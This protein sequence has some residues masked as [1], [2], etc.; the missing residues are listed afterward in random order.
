ME[1][2]LIH[3]VSFCLFSQSWT[4]FAWSLLYY[5]YFTFSCISSFLCLCLSRV[6]P[7]TWRRFFCALFI[8]AWWDGWFAAWPP[9]SLDMP[10]RM[11]CFKYFLSKYLLQCFRDLDLA[12]LRC[13]FSCLP[14][15]T[16]LAEDVKFSGVSWKNTYSGWVFWLILESNFMGYL[17][18][19]LYWGKSWATQYFRPNKV[20]YR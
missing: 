11:G 17:G 4:G 16:S 18:L 2:F 14:D 15:A 5:A 13:V 1:R 9:Q 20:W 12:C 19:Q 6:F 10:V 7:A 8:P 3:S